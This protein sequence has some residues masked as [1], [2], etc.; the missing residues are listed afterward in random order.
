[1]FYLGVFDGVFVFIRGFISDLFDFFY[2]EYCLIELFDYIV[3][4]NNINN[5]ISDFINAFI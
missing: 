5:N 2:L 4:I 1:M 3:I